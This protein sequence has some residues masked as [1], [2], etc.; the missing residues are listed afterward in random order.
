MTF[1]DLGMVVVF[2]GYGLLGWAMVPG[3]WRGEVPDAGQVRAA[4]GVRRVWL[5]YRHEF[6]RRRTG[7]AHLFVVTG[8]LLTYLGV[9]LHDVT[10]TQAVYVGAG[11]I[12]LVTAAFAVLWAVVA[13]FHRPRFVVP[14]HLRDYEE[15]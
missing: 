7:V 3:T 5:H 1:L 2:G 12:G 4:T 10:G 11:L 8:L 15:D 9:R 6:G 14:P 13:A